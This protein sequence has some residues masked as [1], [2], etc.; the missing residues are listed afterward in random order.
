M[1][2]YELFFI[3]QDN[4]PPCVYMKPEWEKLITQN[5][6]SDIKF[7]YLNL[8]QDVGSRDKVAEWGVRSTPSFVITNNGELVNKWIGHKGLKDAINW[9]ENLEEKVN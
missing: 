4:C 3:S 1:N 9:L 8:S 7:N 5:Q 6:N 2:N